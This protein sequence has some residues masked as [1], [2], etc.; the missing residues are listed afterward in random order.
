MQNIKRSKQKY[1][2]LTLII[3]GLIVITTTVMA[4]PPFYLDSQKAQEIYDLRPEAIQRTISQPSSVFDCSISDTTKALVKSSRQGFMTLSKVENI[5]P[6]NGKNYRGAVWSHTGDKAVFVVATDQVK[7]IPKIDQSQPHNFSPIAIIQSELHLFTIA[8]QTWQQIT[9]DGVRPVW[10]TDDQTIYYMQGTTLYAIEVDTFST[11][12]IDQTSHTDVWSLILSRPL[13]DGGLIDTGS[14]MGLMKVKASNSLNP[15]NQYSQAIAMLP[16]DDMFVS[17]TGERL[18]V[19]N[20]SVEDEA[21]GRF[22]EGVTTVYG[23]NQMVMPI[24]KNCQNSVNKLAWSLDGTRIAFPV[25]GPQQELK[26]FNLDTGEL[27]TLLRSDDPDKFSGLSWSSDGA[28]LA[29]TKGD[30]RDSARTIWVVALDGSKQQYLTE[31]MLPNWSPDNRHLLYARPGKE[32]N[33]DWFLAEI[34]FEN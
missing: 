14:Q 24:L 30:G 23:P 28:Y 8:N 11:S 29:F 16:G 31:G 25:S 20:G 21:S 26:V 5:L 3:V 12:E 2:Y 34:Q 1:L 27:T 32:N 13:A 9:D 6:N 15:Q 33:L 17:P 22:V 18:I 19:A 10:S 7:P 4:D